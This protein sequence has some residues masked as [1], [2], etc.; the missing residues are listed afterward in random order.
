MSIN[1]E[2]GTVFL[3]MIPSFIIFFSVISFTLNFFIYAYSSTVLSL[4]AQEAGR[5]TISSFR[6]DVGQ[7]AGMN[8]LKKYGI[9]HLI[10]NPS[11]SV[12]VKKVPNLKDS[13]IEATANGDVSYTPLGTRF[14]E[15]DGVTSKT[16]RYYMERTFQENEYQFVINRYGWD[17]RGTCMM[18]SW[19]D[20]YDCY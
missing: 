19:G 1:N 6:A 2:K 8:Y 16:V 12:S 11:I 10:K 18:S 17:I 4:A 14:F 5:I 3:E 7:Q 13:V 9:G 15:K 20:E